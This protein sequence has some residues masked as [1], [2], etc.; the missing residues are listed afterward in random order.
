[1]SRFATNLRILAATSRPAVACFLETIARVDRIDPVGH[2]VAAHSD[3]VGVADVAALDIALDPVAALELCAD[4]HRQRQ[5]LPIAAFVCCPYCVTPWNLRALFAAGVSSVMDLQAS[6]AE[7]L[8]ALET[9]ANGASV[10]HLHLRRGHRELLREVLG[11]TAPRSEMQIRLLE[12]VALGL[13]DHEI[14]RRL[15]LSPHTVKHHI[16]QLRNDV[17]AKNRIE[18]AAWAG[19]HGF[20]SRDGASGAASVPVV[21]TRPPS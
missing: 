4:L 17:G 8:R 9:V 6:A 20:Y 12:L 11:G 14:G 18:L 15:Y 13:P 5:E 7:T 3:L 2:D 1:M 16:E 10:L 19:R 21:V